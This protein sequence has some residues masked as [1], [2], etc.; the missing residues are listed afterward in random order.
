MHYWSASIGLGVLTDLRGPLA[1][2]LVPA[3]TSGA[4]ICCFVCH[5]IKLV[6]YRSFACFNNGLRV[7]WVYEVI[8]LQW[9]EDDMYICQSLFVPRKL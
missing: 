3:A 5:F 4:R 9:I 1:L 6:I 2:Q 8:A 7:G